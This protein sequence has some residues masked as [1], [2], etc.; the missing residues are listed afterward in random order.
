ML[1]LPIPVH[2]GAVHRVPRVR[3]HPGGL[4]GGEGVEKVPTSTAPLEL[5]FTVFSLPELV[6]RPPPPPRWEESGRDAPAAAHPPP[7]C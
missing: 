1:A 2:P 7:L 6:F 4:A 3:T 5:V